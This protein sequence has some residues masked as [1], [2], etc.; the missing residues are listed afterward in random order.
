M[1]R[2]LEGRDP[3]RGVKFRSCEANHRPDLVVRPYRLAEGEF[4]FGEV[5]DHGIIYKMLYCNLPDDREFPHGLPIYRKEESRVKRPSWIW[6]DNEESP[7]LTPSILSGSPGDYIW[8]G[9]LT[10]G[11]FKACE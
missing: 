3:G 8:H 7:T 6:D 5:N 9:Y 10:A 2:V 1:A 11:Q 4:C